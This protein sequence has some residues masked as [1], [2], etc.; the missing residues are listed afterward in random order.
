MLNHQ[1]LECYQK[2]VRLVK[3]LANL[4]PN[5]PGRAQLKDQAE[6]AAISAILNLAEGCGKPTPKDRRKFFAISRGSIQEFS[7]CID[8]ARA[9]GLIS[10]PHYNHF[11][12]ELLSMV[13]MV[14][15]LITVQ[16]QFQ[17]SS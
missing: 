8:I 9:L 10:Q 16:G 3:E 11:Q 1:R 5:W 6:R 14:S 2:G 12:S 17:S 13:K 4:M 7:A 15:R